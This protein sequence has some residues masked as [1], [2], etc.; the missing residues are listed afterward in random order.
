[1]ENFS[2]Q[3]L[4]VLRQ[5]SDKNDVEQGVSVIKQI[6]KFENF[7]N[8]IIT[9]VVLAFIA[10]IKKIV[11]QSVK[12]ALTNLENKIIEKRQQVITKTKQKLDA[13][14]QKALE[15]KQLAL[16]KKKLVQ[17][18][19]KE[20]KQVDYKQKILEERAKLIAYFQHTPPKKAL[21]LGLLYFLKPFEKAWI[22]IKAQLSWNS[23]GTY[24]TLTAIAIGSGTLIWKNVNNIKNYG[25]KPANTGPV[26]KYQRPYYYKQTRKHSLFTNLKLPV[27]YK[28]KKNVTSLTIDFNIITDYRATLQEIEKHH[29]KI[30]DHLLMNVEP[31]QAEFPL[32]NEGREILKSKIQFELN[33]YLKKNKIEG[34]I[35]EVQIM[36]VLGT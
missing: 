7:A 5:I 24:F 25:R 2:Q 10:L 34:S 18:K 31:V 23:I 14:K 26:Y 19:V 20:L 28:S 12:D 30:R 35:K 32:E 1:M 17:E 36:Y 29:D 16:E 8:R 33:E 6:I 13:I 22:W 4:K 11:P 3:K 21:W 27:Y 15:K 9:K